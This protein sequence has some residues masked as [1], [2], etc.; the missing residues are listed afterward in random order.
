M[1]TR[2]IPR[3]EWAHFFS[4]FSAR[5]DDEEVSIHVIS[6][7]IGAHAE[8]HDLHL[9]GI[10]H[11]RKSDDLAFAL[12]LDTDEGTHLTHM[13]PRPVQVRVTRN[14]FGNTDVLEISSADGTTTVV[15]P[16]T[17]PTVE[18]FPRKGDDEDIA[19]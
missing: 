2:E 14:A 18:R 11:V 3:S 15:R 7:K 4:D 9:R 10:A 5:H 1:E 8:A 17:R 19:E 6:P 12:E 16:G 13:V